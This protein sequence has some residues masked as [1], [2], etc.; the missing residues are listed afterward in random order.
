M[1]ARRS[2][3]ATSVLDNQL[4]VVGGFDGR[5]YLKSVETYDFVNKTWQ[6]RGSMNWRRLGCGVGVLHVPALEMLPC[7]ETEPV[8]GPSNRSY[9]TPIEQS[10]PEQI[11][12]LTPTP[13]ESTNTFLLADADDS[14]SIDTEYSIGPSTAST[15]PVDVTLP[16]CQNTPEQSPN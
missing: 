5:S 1:S 7:Y 9:F 2:G 4:V 3:V 6:P 10:E 14:E 16:H 11:L 15:L 8:H 12:D 13:T